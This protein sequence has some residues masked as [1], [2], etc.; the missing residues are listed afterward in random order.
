M[1]VLAD[2]DIIL[3]LAQS[4]L[5]DDLPELF[6]Q[7]WSEIFIT[8]TAKYQLLP[9]KAEKA[10]VKCGTQ[11]TLEH[12]TAFLN[13]TQILPEVQD[14]KL[15]ARL[16]DID[17]IDSGEKL[18]FAAAVELEN[19]LLI[20]GDRRALC[21]LL[22]NKDQL[23]TVFSALQ[24]AVVTFESAL[25][26]AMHNLGFAIVKSKLLASPLLNS[27]KPDGMLRLAV[28]SESGQAEFVECLCSYSKEVI[29]LLAFKTQLPPILNPS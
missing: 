22:E 28:K 10:L 27:P 25:L 8:P 4:D 26:L 24:N 11:E 6:G 5:L 9:K 17:G 1:I 21:T 7:A 16:D 13:T 29:P 2:N 15:L 19:P 20:T 23:P 18:L 12:L 3:K 14:Q